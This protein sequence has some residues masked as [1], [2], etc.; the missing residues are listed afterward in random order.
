MGLFIVPSTLFNEYAA[1]FTML[2][3]FSNWPWSEH[4]SSISDLQPSHI[5]LGRGESLRQMPTGPDGGGERKI[6][7]WDWGITLFDELHENRVVPTDGQP[8]AVLIFLNDHASLNQP[9]RE[10]EN[11]RESI[12]RRELQNWFYLTVN[13]FIKYS[14]G[15]AYQSRLQ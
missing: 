7:I 13:V 8:K 15:E 12:I 2:Y 5:S 10:G 3:V 9:W 14:P 11:K 1:S 6:G 4:I